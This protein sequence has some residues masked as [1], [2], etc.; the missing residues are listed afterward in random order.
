LAEVGSS[1]QPA[2]H[3]E[4][5]VVLKEAEAYVSSSDPDDVRLQI[6][7]VESVANKITAAMLAMS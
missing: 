7:R 4:I 5:A 2:D 3:Q 6:G 1:I